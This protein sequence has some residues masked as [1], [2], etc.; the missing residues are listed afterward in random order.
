MTGT[1]AGVDPRT[2]D[3]VAFWVAERDS[4]ADYATRHLGMH[5]IDRQDNFTLIGSDALH[6]KLTLFDADGP[7][8]RGAF[9]HV[10]LRV[11]A[12]NGADRHELPEGI[13]VRIVEARTDVEW[14]LDHVALLSHD[15]ERTASRTKQ[16]GQ[17][18][19]P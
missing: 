6:G 17:A 12:R 7:R 2:L 15:P 14:D 9:K 10:A 5:V 4:I 16:A 11:S 13:E 3:H 18:S 19:Q 8:E 1:L